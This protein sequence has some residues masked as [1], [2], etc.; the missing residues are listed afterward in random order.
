MCRYRGF[1]FLSMDIR[2]S[3]YFTKSMPQTSSPD[4]TPKLLLSV[5]LIN[6]KSD[7][8]RSRQSPLIL[9]WGIVL[10]APGE[11]SAWDYPG[12]AVT[13]QQ[14]FPTA[15]SGRASHQPS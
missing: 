9:F 11:A 5:A 14:E 1:P 15:T 6:Q 13:L 4:I 10:C 7:A 8:I 12:Q 3:S 2:N